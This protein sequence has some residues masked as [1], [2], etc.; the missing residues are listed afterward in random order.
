VFATPTVAGDLIFIGSCS[1]WFYALEKKSGQVRWRYDV[2]KDGIPSEFHGDPLLADSLVII[3]SDGR[4]TG[5]VY[6][7]VQ[8]TGKRRW[9]FPVPRGVPVDLALS[10]NRLY[11]VTYSDSLLCLDLENGRVQWR[12][13]GETFSRNRFSTHAPVAA[14]DHVYFATSDRKLHALQAATGQILWTKIFDA[15]ISSEMLL[16]QNRLYIGTAGSQIYCLDRMS[17]ETLH[18]IATGNHSRDHAGAVGK[19]DSLSK[20]CCTL[21]CRSAECRL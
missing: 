2:K 6:A 8:T 11:V 17:G 10:G 16:H 14:N 5:H 19:S 13:A 3:A 4:G 18:Q 12:C 1:G 15:R 21:L 9:K 7:F 20:A